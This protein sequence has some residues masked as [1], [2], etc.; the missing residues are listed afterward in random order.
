MSTPIPAH[1][2][3][4]FDGPRPVWIRATDGTIHP[5]REAAMGHRAAAAERHE[6]ARA[7]TLDLLDGIPAIAVG[8]PVPTSS[9]TASHACPRCGAPA[10]D[11]H[12]GAAQGDMF[13]AQI[14]LF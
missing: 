7:A 8:R 6:Q 1:E 2:L 4:L 14:S 9:A 13:D 3:S 11:P 10:D 5:T 12:D